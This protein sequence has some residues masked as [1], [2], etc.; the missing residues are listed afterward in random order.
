[1]TNWEIHGVEFGNCNCAYGCPCQFNAPPTYGN[2]E[3]VDFVRIDRGHFGETRLDGLNMAFAVSWPG[4]VHE[5]GGAMQPVLD[6]RA[7]AAQR[8]ALLSIMTGQHTA[9]M[10]TVFAVYTAMC[11]TIHE[12]IVAAIRI[13]LDMAARTAACEAQG[14][15]V[16]RG[17]PIRNPVTGEEHRVGIHLPDGFEYTLNECGRGWSSSQGKIELAL[18]DSYAHWCELHMNQQGVIR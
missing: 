18:E 3:A 15:I 8:E 5:G 10:S 13:E 16:G 6:A 4:A 11:E 12:P 2:C 9:P 17:E 7:D 1:M 14:V